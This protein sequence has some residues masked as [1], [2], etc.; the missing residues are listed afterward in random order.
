MPADGIG[1]AKALPEKALDLL[2]EQKG[3]WWPGLRSKG[4][5]VLD[6]V[7]GAGYGRGTLTLRFL[8]HCG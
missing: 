2:K 7:A 8:L 6:E 5:S 4:A 3:A 1:C